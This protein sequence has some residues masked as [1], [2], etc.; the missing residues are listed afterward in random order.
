M[1]RNL[2]CLFTRTPRLMRNR[3]LLLAVLLS[4]MSCG[5][6]AS[7]TGT[8]NNGNGTGTGVTPTVTTSVTLQN[9]AFNPSSIQVSAGAVVTYTNSDGIAHNV[10][11]SSATIGGTGDFTTGAKTLTMPTAAGSYDYHC[12]IHPGM[13]G[14]VTVK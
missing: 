2:A 6:A 14:S 4:S 10:T 11:F 5:G 8:N 9:T 12:S 13:T 1:R 3:L 7:S